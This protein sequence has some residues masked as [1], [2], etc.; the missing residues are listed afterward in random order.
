MSDAI[1]RDQSTLANALQDVV[2]IRTGVRL[3][4]HMSLELSMN[5]VRSLPLLRT[6]S[7]QYQ[8]P[9]PCSGAC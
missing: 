9:G 8:P 6:D 1:F 3:A 7:L 4:I 2:V 5:L